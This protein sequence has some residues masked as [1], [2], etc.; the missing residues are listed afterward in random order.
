MSAAHGKT[1][2]KT[3]TAGGVSKT[4]TFGD[5]HGCYEIVKE[6]VAI[7]TYT[8]KNY[9]KGLRAHLEAYPTDTWASFMESWVLF[10]GSF[11]E[12]KKAGIPNVMEKD[13]A[14]YV[15]AFHAFLI[16]LFSMT[17]E[18]ITQL[19]RLPEDT[20]ITFKHEKTKKTASV[21]QIMKQLVKF[22]ADLNEINEWFPAYVKAEREFVEWRLKKK[23]GAASGGGFSVVL[24]GSKRRPTTTHGCRPVRGGRPTTTHGSRPVVIRDDFDEDNGGGFDEDN[25]GGFDE[26]DISRALRASRAGGFDEDDIA[27]A[28]SASLAGG[29]DEDDIARALSASLA[30]GSPYHTRPT[31]A[32]ARIN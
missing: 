15:E 22:N 25:G 27:R 2:D 11:S 19:G 29:F 10:K 12:I 16:A 24:R 30:D 6:T 31:R 26:D 21:E 28:L 5:R 23:T 4:I 20:M 18:A 1:R 7:D 17:T 8:A 14:V 9:V 32:H 3:V 13:R